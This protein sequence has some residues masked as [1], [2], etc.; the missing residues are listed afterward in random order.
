M[1]ARGSE[2]DGKD[3]NKLREF[4]KG[5]EAQFHTSETEKMANC[6]LLNDGSVEE[7]YAGADE[8]CAKLGF[9]KISE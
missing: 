5:E 1:L 2:R 4:D 6:K 9:K 7:F 3:V 8:I